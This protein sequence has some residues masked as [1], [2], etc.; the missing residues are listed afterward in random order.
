MRTFYKVSIALTAAAVVVAGTAG[1]LHVYGKYQDQRQERVA[2]EELQKKKDLVA[3]YQNI[4]YGG[5]SVGEEELEG[6]NAEELTEVL[7]AEA[8]KYQNR[9][10]SIQVDEDAYSYTMKQLKEKIYYSCSDGSEYLLGQEKM[11]AEK[12]V[13]LDKEKNLEDQYE[14]IKGK[15]KPTELQVVILCKLNKKQLDR[16]ME[17]LENR[18]V[19]PVTNSHIDEHGKITVPKDG[20]DLDI[21]TIRKELRKYL[22]QESLENYTASYQTTVSKPIWKQKDLR[23]VNT[24][25]SRFSTTFVST[26]QRGHNIKVGASRMNGTCLLPGE[27]VS[28]D[29]VI[30]D[31]SDGQSFLEAGSYLHGKV[32][33]TEGGGIC[34]IST[35]AYNALLQ[36]GIIPVRRYPHSMPVHYVPLG[37][38]A[39]ISAGVKDLEVKNTLNVPILILAQ[40]KGNT[41]T[42]SIKSY[43]GALGGYTY[44]PRAVQLSSLSAKGYLDVYKNGRKQKSILLHTD[45]YQS[46]S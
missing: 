46:E 22:N 35:T 26:T 8:K 37:L 23:K 10:V 4:T 17:K 18:Y 11:L 43:R 40:T 39:A 7:Q 12:M 27:S 13:G 33:Q 21:K 41:L 25:I 28:F 29:K 38:D 16:I 24:E 1:G 9:T 32:V 20:Q 2:A 36:A 15:A 6:L 3:D 5:K 42:F 44:K 34:Q 31:E 14:I 45:R 19:I 30:H